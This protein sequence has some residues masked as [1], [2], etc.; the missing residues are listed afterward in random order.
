MFEY[1]REIVILI[2]FG[3][4]IFIPFVYGLLY[5]I[6][7]SISIGWNVGKIRM[8]QLENEKIKLIT[9]F[10]EVNNKKERNE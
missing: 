3:F 7:A 8:A 9:E 4:I 1:W 5:A 10:N 6:A 2:L